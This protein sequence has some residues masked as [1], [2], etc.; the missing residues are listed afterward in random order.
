[1]PADILEVLKCWL[2]ARKARVAVGGQFPRDMVIRDMAYQGIVLGPPLWTLFFEDAAMAIRFHDFFAR[3]FSQTTLNAY[4]AFQLTTGNQV[5]FSELKR[6]QCEVHIW[7][8][9]NQ[10]S[11]DASKESMHILALKD[12][13]SD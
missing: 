8:K 12:G 9:A 4:K 6:C 3:W 2:T 7:G 1:M 10:V 5:M 11:S 13:I